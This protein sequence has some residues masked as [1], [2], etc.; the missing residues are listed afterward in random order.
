M[1]AKRGIKLFKE[2]A[3]AAMISKFTQ[4]DQGAMP[5]KPVVIPIHPR[6]ITAQHKQQ[7]LE[8]VNLIRR[9]KCRKIKGCTCADG[10]KQQDYLKDGKDYLSPTISLKALFSTMLIDAH[11]GRYI[12]TFDIPGA[13]LHAKIPKDKQV[14]LKLRDKFVDIMCEVN[15]EHRENVVI[16]NGKR[17]LYLQVVQTTYGCIELALLWY[18]LYAS[19]LQG[20]GLEIN[21]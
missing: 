17:V 15:E 7:V 19:T 18:D 21:L 14:I 8:A 10:S 5:G 11:K 12:A 1:L 2:R 16:K 3:I 4:L 6:N 9:K 13:Y 20:M